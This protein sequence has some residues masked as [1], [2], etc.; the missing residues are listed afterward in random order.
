MRCAAYGDGCF[1][2]LPPLL[3]DRIGVLEAVS[4][5]DEPAAGDQRGAADVAVAIHLEADLPRPR[6]CP[7]VR[8]PHDLSAPPGPGTAAS[9]GEE[10][11]RGRRHESVE[12]RVKDAGNLRQRSSSEPSEQ[13]LTPS[14]S[15][16]TLFTHFPLEHLKEDEEQVLTSGQ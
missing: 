14:H 11:E 3:L 8:A 13:S 10:R 7:R 9:G 6:P 5:G 12:S 16:L 15:G 4:G 2:F 1:L